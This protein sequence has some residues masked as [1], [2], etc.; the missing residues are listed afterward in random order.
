MREPRL[1]PVRR[2]RLPRART[3]LRLMLVAALLLTA[4]AALYAGEPSCPP[5]AV[6][7]A[8]TPVPASGDQPSADR[9]PDARGPGEPAPAHSAPGSSR[10]APPSGTV[11]VP[12][13]L[14]DP[15]ALAL[16]HPGDRVD[17]L[18]SGRQPAVLATDALVLAVALDEGALLLALGPAQARKTASARPGTAFS[19]IVR[20]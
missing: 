17:L 13:R 18:A 10:L 6:S 14:A 19:I 16:V 5:P 20:R 3:T 8:S 4:A 1:D 11:G 9:T 2:P 15:A 7:G 12:V